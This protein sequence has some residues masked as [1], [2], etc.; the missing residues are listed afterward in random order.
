MAS[1]SHGVSK[2]TTLASSVYLSF[3]EAFTVSITK[4][5]SLR[6]SRTMSFTACNGFVRTNCPKTSPFDGFLINTWKKI[7]PPSISI[8]NWFLFTALDHDETLTEQGT[9]RDF[10]IHSEGILTGGRK[11][12]VFY[13][14]FI[15]ICTSSN[16]KGSTVLKKIFKIVKNR[17]GRS[18]NQQIKKKWP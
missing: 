4:T 2:G 10:P 15:F 1:T 7:D 17:V 18:V 13:Y 9:A 16:R 5:L 11:A 6:H 8:F 12:D 3:L 14:V